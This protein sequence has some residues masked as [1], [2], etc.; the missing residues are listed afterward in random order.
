VRSTPPI[1]ALGGVGF[2]EHLNNLQRC[3][4]RLTEM[5]EFEREV[6]NLSNL[7]LVANVG[8]SHLFLNARL[9][10][11]RSQAVIRHQEMLAHPERFL[12]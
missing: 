10:I 6:T 3:E 8:T 7:D 9:S 11:L 12:Y 2:V 5:E 1:I 4:A